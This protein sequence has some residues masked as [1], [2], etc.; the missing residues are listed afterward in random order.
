MQ[1]PINLAYRGD[2]LSWVLNLPRSRFLVVGDDHLDWLAKIQDD[3][4]HLDT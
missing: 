3:L 1:C 4:A 2:F